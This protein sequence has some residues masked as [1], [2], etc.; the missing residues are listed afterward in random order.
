MNWTSSPVFYSD[1]R[2][3]DFCYDQTLSVMGGVDMIQFFTDFKLE[4]GT[5]DEAEV[6]QQGSEE[7]SVSLNNYTYNFVT[8]SN[9]RLTQMEINWDSFL[10]IFISNNLILVY[11]RW[12][13]FITCNVSLNNAPEIPFD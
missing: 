6:G 13:H 10:V 12:L 8:E 11:H 4:D 5:Y 3:I 9:L 7:Y 2:S 1:G